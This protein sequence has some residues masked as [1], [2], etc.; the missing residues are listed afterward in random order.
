MSFINVLF[1]N[2]IFTNKYV[3]YQ[4]C[5]GQGCSGCK[6][7]PKS[8]DLLKIWEKFLKIL[9]TNMAPKFEFFFPKPK[10]NTWRPF[11]EVTPLKGLYDLCKMKFVGKSPTK[12]FRE[13]LGKFGQKSFAPPKICLLS[14][15]CLPCTCNCTSFVRKHDCHLA[16]Y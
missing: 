1:F 8:F 12:S 6:P 10:K 3:S 2:Y 7:T 9:A 4:W 5:R 15:P 16:I 11:L 13:S 14:H